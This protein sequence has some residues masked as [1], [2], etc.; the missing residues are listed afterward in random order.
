MK[1]GISIILILALVL[2]SFSYAF[3]AVQ[4]VSD[5]TTHNKLTSI[6]SLL[7]DIKGALSGT[8]SVLSYIQTI[9]NNIA[10]VKDAVIW[11]SGESTNNLIYF[12]RNCASYL[13]NIETAISTGTIAGLSTILNNI[14]SELTWTDAGQNVIHGVRFIVDRINTIRT[15]TTNIA[16]DTATMKV[17]IADLMTEVL[18]DLPLIQTNTYNTNSNLETIYTLE[19]NTLPGIY[20]YSGSIDGT[21]QAM[22][23]LQQAQLPKL[24]DLKAALTNYNQAF[25][26]DELTAAQFA[27]YAHRNLIGAAGSFPATPWYVLPTALNNGGKSTQSVNWFYGTP[28]GNLMVALQRI[29]EN[30]VNTYQWRWSAD[31]TNYNSTQTRTNW[32]TLASETFT[33]SSAVDG[34]YK[35]FGSIQTPIARLASVHASDEEIQARE[36]AANNQAAVTNNFINPSGSGSVPTSSFGSVSSLSSG[37]KTNLTTD[38]SPSGIFDIFNSSHGTWFSQETANQLDTTQNTRKGS[39]FETPLLDQQIEDIY[40]SLGVKK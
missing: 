11:N 29:N 18:L 26:D 9:S 1:K 16:S 33:P 31:L 27:K 10:S 28:I 15:N 6:N 35:W 7:T 40:S 36:Y 22:N 24:E 37:V 30:F 17:N 20:A 34:I 4:D 38:A 3:A 32:K 14:L 13:S 19:N 23:T 2:G 25:Y 5:A 21:T 39:S 12:V 8:N